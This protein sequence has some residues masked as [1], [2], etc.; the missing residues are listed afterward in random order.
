MNFFVTFVSLWFASYLQKICVYL[1]SS[2]DILQFDP[3]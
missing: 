1:C 3:P 2:V